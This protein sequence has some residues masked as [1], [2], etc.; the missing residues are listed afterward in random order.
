MATSFQ[1]R[2]PA[3]KARNFKSRA[4]SKQP[5]VL[6]IAKPTQW[7]NDRRDMAAFTMIAALYAR[8]RASK[9]VGQGRGTTKI[10]DAEQL[11]AEKLSEGIC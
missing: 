6:C 3:A 1:P 2:V 4:N 5:Y 11:V 8:A 7:R 9:W 10:F